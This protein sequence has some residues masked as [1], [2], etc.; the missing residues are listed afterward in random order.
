MDFGLAAIGIS[1]LLSICVAWYLILP[2]F[3]D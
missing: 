3:E 1:L 2:F